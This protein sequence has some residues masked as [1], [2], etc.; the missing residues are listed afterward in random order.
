VIM[1]RWVFVVIRRAL[2]TSQPLCKV[3]T[4]AD[5]QGVDLCFWVPQ[6]MEIYRWAM[7]TKI[8]ANRKKPRR[9]GVRIVNTVRISLT[10]PG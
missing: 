10:G 4:L 8:S 6:N 9:N 3:L 5:V 7:M 1:K 2:M